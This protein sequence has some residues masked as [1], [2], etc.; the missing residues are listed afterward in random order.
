M[1]MEME[2]NDTVTEHLNRLAAAAEALTAA[3]SRIEQ[4]ELALEASVNTREAELEAKLQAAETTLAQLR[5]Q[6]SGRK[7]TPAGVPTLAA[8]GFT[9]EASAADTLKQVD[10][11]LTSLSLEQRIAV[12]AQMLRDGLLR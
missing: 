7:T 11:A 4:R 6:A 10:A 2:I 8:K 5:A 12:K 9:V 1:D 3:A